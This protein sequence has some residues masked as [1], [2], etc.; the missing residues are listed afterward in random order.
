[1]LRAIAIGEKAFGGKHPLMTSALTG[2]AKVYREQ[3]RLEEA[4]ALFKKA[5]ALVDDSLDRGHPRMAEAL[6]GQASIYMLG[7]DYDAAEVLFVE[8]LRLLDA[9]FGPEH[10]E[11]AR[12]LE[13][14]AK[15]SAKL[16]K[17]AESAQYAARV[18][19]IRATK[20]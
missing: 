3:D 18:E 8:A 7:E 4:L 15:A 6:A 14:L 17:Q 5:T 10:P 20:R 13:A 19:K 12:T 9:A 2:L 16:G 11:T 1:M